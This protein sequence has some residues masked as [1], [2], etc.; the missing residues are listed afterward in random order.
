[1]SKPLSSILITKSAASQSPLDLSQAREK[2]RA[3]L[4][5]CES[6]RRDVDRE[7]RYIQARAAA[8]HDSVNVEAIRLRKCHPAS[9]GDDQDDLERAYQLACQKRSQA[10][11]ILMAARRI[12]PGIGGPPSSRVIRKSVGLQVLLSGKQSR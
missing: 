10:T 6:L 4:A 9:V 7:N 11:Q 12:A 2:A 5:S 1:M 8:T 3:T